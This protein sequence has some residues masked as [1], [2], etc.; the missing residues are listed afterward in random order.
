MIFPQEHFQEFF[1]SFLSL[2]FVTDSAWG[3]GGGGGGG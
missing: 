3:G 2:S 1:F